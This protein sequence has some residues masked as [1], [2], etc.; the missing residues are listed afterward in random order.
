MLKCIK[1][2][3]RYYV[4][5]RWN[6]SYIKILSVEGWSSFFS[7]RRKI[8]HTFKVISSHYDINPHKSINIVLTVNTYQNNFSNKFPPSDTH[9][10]STKKKN[11]KK[12][13]CH[14]NTKFSGVVLYYYQPIKLNTILYLFKV[15]QW[16][17]NVKFE[18]FSSA[19]LFLEPQSEQV[20]FIKNSIAFADCTLT[21]NDYVRKQFWKYFKIMLRALTLLTNLYRLYGLYYSSEKSE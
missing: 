11:V 9:T 21:D 1:L 6:A 19:K 18:H 20:D 10:N 12:N 15:E 8:H 3:S 13:Y 14:R 17:K 4:K 5:N 2:F 16:K 7:H